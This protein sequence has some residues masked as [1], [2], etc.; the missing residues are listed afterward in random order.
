MGRKGKYY[1]VPFLYLIA[2]YLPQFG[3][4][5]QGRNIPK[6]P[7]TTIL[8]SF[9]HIAIKHSTTWYI[10]IYIYMVCMVIL[11]TSLHL[12][13]QS[14]QQWLCVMDLVENNSPLFRTTRNLM[15]IGIGYVHYKTVYHENISLLI[16]DLF[17][18]FWLGLGI[19]K[20]RDTIS[21]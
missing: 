11:S 8:F 9:K 3:N 5:I 14:Y 13:L 6:A 18:I 20:V 15:T 10:Y 17:L 19:L 21:F 12:Y 1:K 7:C 16:V 2:R 4:L